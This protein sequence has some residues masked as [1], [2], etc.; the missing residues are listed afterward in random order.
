MTIIFPGLSFIFP[1]SFI[2]FSRCACSSACK[3]KAVAAGPAASEAV[4][5]AFGLSFIPSL[6]KS[7]AGGGERSMTPDR[8]TL[9][10]SWPVFFYIPC[11]HLYLAMSDTS[12]SDV[13]LPPTIH[14]IT[15]R[16]WL[17]FSLAIP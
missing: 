9:F 16:E 12:R 2:P 6:T 3:R 10:P 17:N 5:E 14:N 15:I 8:L 4:S 11:M 7:Y 13:L 1:L